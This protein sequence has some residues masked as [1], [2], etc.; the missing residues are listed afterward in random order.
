MDNWSDY[1]GLTNNINVS[2]NAC[3][4]ERIKRIGQAVKKKVSV[5][6]KMCETD[7]CEGSVIT[8][9]KKMECVKGNNTE[10]NS[11]PCM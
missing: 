3:L 2:V 5:I 11:N 6:R 9:A 1:S 4:Q 7:V 10:K 8:L